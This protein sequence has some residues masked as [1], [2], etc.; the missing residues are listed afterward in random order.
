MP[1]SFIKST[2]EFF[3]SNFCFELADRSSRT[4][5]IS[6]WAGAGAVAVGAAGDAVAAAALF[7]FAASFLAL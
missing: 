6:T 4:D 7:S 1:T 3:Q 2:I 5:M